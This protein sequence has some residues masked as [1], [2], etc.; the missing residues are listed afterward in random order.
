MP[1]PCPVTHIQQHGRQ[2]QHVLI[3][4]LASLRTLFDHQL[5]RRGNRCRLELAQPFHRRIQFG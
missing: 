1:G 2:R 3:L 4:R 5:D